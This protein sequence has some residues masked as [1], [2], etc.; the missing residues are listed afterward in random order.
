MEIEAKG[1][2]PGLRW[3]QRC[4]AKEQHPPTLGIHTQLFGPVV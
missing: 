2:E 1:H 3:G 4:G